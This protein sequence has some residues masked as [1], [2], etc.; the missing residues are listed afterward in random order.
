MPVTGIVLN[1]RETKD[2]AREEFVHF[3]GS[4]SCVVVDWLAGWLAGSLPTFWGAIL[5]MPGVSAYLGLGYEGMQLR[6]DMGK[7]HL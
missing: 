1:F 7:L 3:S 4:H 6:C 5:V 2:G